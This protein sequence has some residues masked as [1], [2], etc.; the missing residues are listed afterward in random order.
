MPVILSAQERAAV[1][2]AQRQSRNVRHWR[3]Y[4]A[5]LLRAEGMSVQQVAQRLG[6][7]ETS[8]YNWSAAYRQEG[9]AGVQEGS[10]P[11][12][13]R[14]LDA[15]GEAML[16][17]LLTENDPQ[18]HGYQ[19]TGWTVPLLQSDLAARGYRA[20]AATIRRTLHRLG[21]RWKRP[22]FVLGRPDPAY[23][24]KKRGG[25]ASGGDGGGGRCGLVWRR[26]NVARVP[27]AAL[28]LGAPRR[29]GG[30]GGQRTHQRTHQPPGGAWRTQRG[31]R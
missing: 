14:R 1:A 22:K 8:V 11:G 27:T 5:V 15:A 2:G 26:D 18:A 20:S 7:T 29:T 12:A 21:W 23:A 28:S 30:R 6:C 25:R 24:E 31:D 4:Q 13:A 10:H 3:R 9:V 17:A 16:T 19:A